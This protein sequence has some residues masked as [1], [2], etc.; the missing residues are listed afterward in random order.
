AVAAHG[1]LSPSTWLAQ[2]LPYGSRQLAHRDRSL[3]A[4]LD[5][6]VRPDQKRPRLGRKVPL[7]EPAVVAER[8]VVVLVDLDVDEAD[9]AALEARAHDID[10]V[11]DRPARAAG[12]EL[13]RREHEH[14]RLVRGERPGHGVVE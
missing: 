7:L 12:A 2:I 1:A 9:A 5:P 11:D 4:R 14:E 13:R 6:P 8:D 10:D 3:E